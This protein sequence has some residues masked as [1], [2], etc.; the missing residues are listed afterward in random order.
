MASILRRLP[1]LSRA[2][3]KPLAF[4]SIPFKQISWQEKLEEDLLPDY[5]ASRYY[6]VRLG[7]VDHEISMYSRISAASKRHPGR[8]SVRE[9]L[10]SFEVAGP[11]G[12]P[13]CGRASWR[14][15]TVT[16]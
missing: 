10:D 3:W 6:P 14:S 8:R 11:D 15:F 4:P 12:C 13:R 2:A 5:V 7:Q 9:L 16:P 1:W